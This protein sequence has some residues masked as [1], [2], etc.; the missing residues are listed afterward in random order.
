MVQGVEEWN[1]MAM[2]CT[3]TQRVRPLGVWKL[4][5]V[6][7]PK[8]LKTRRVWVWKGWEMRNG[9]GSEGMDNE[10]GLGF[11]RCGISVVGFL[12]RTAL[13]LGPNAC[14]FFW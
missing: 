9:R 4:R 6:G 8:L 12:L 14:A 2:V 1:E 13:V 3:Q 11:R 5:K 10:T 7:V